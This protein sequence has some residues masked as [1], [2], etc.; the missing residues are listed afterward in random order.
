MARRRLLLLGG[1]GQV[2]TALRRLAPERDWSVSAPERSALD[3]A[4]ADR[5]SLRQA[6]AAADLVLNAAAYT[7]VDQAE[8]D[9]DAAVAAN[10][11]GPGL[12]ARVCAEAERPLLHLSTDYVFD[13]SGTRPYRED[14]PVAP[15]GVYGAS[16]AAGEAA[17]RAAGPRHVILRT[18]W[19][20]SPDGANFLRTMLRL[21]R[22]RPEVRVVDDQ[23]GC[24]TAA[25]DIA[26]ACLGIADRLAADGRTADRPDDASPLW[27]TFH[28]AGAPATTW[29]GFAAAIFAEAERRGLPVPRLL[30][31]TT[32]DYPTPTRRPAFSVLD[33]TR[34]ETTYGIAAPDWRAGVRRCLDRLT[35]H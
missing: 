26:A 14:D 11:T 6:V 29:H 3:L 8:T 35:A 10:A 5:D 25:D 18:A 9:R 20:F 31:I 16:K 12:L 27:G 4:T 24:P 32:A 22:E 7:R 28:F 33:C 34:I 21:G 23:R 19:V 17:V 13:G 1:T 30:P 2:G 15:L